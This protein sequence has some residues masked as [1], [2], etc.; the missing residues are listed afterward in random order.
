MLIY[1][2]LV[3]NKSS[4]LSLLGAVDGFKLTSARAFV[5]VDRRYIALLVGA[6]ASS[7]KN[8]V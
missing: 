1:I 3:H 8:T 4:G 5:W 6:P 2:S 7:V